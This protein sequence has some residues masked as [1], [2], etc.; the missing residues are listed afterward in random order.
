MRLPTQKEAWPEHREVHTVPKEW[1]KEIDSQ[2]HLPPQ[3]FNLQLG[4]QVVAAVIVSFVFE[5]ESKAQNLPLQGM[6]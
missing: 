1:S 6:G 2:L 5:V 3:A 4:P